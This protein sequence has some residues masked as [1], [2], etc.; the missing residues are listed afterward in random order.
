MKFKIFAAVALA[1]ASSFS[2]AASYDW[3]THD[4]VEAGGGFASGAGASLSDTF[5]FSLSSQTGVL[6]VAVSNDGGLFNLTGG[7]V[8]LFKEGSK[9]AIGSFSFDKDATS[10]SFGSLLAGNYFYTVTGK[11][12]SDAFAATYQL[13]SQLAPV[14]EPETYALMLA[15]LGAVGFVARRRQPR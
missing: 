15:G 3:G 9:T 2:Q 10:F 4:I 1:A 7:K 13:N 5:K 11:V 8:E 6:A 14:P 12:A